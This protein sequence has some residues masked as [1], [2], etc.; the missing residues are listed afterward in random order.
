MVSAASANWKSWDDVPVVL[1]SGQ[2][3]VLIGVRSPNTLRKLVNGGLL[4]RST[5]KVGLGYKFA[6]EAVRKFCQSNGYDPFPDLK[7]KKSM[8]N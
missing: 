2:V 6:R 3:M 5:K 8:R 1:D 4:E 7:N